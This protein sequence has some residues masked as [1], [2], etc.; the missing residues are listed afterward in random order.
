MNTVKYLKDL[1]SRREETWEGNMNREIK[2]QVAV[3]DATFTFPVIGDPFQTHI[4]VL[5]NENANLREVISKK[6]SEVPK[7]VLDDIKLEQKLLEER[8]VGDLQN[9]VESITKDLD[10]LKKIII[11][12]EKKFR[13][14][15]ST[16]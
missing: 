1:I 4:A 3:Q 16:G 15:L 11:K 10:K 8:K 13:W 5:Q 14:H 9:F 6:D 2:L 7:E 12:Y